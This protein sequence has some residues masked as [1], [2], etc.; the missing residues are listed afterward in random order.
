MCPPAHTRHPRGTHPTHAWPTSDTRPTH[1]R[2]TSGKSGETRRTASCQLHS[3]PLHLPL[4]AGTTLAHP[5]PAPRKP[6][7]AAITSIGSVVRLRSYG[8]I[9]T[10]PQYRP[11]STVSVAYVNSAIL[12]TPPSLHPHPP[13]PLRPPFYTLN[14]PL[15]PTVFSL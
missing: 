15:G 6:L 11:R 2:H 10:I 13:N 8:E 7:P 14:F 9:F 12:S 1:V 4:P 5:P 3:T